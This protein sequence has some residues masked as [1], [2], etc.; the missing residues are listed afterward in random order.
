MKKLILKL[1]LLV[2]L[3]IKIYD[4]CNNVIINTYY[5]HSNIRLIFF[6]MF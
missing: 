1:D 3:N 2:T 4:K 6:K 5:L